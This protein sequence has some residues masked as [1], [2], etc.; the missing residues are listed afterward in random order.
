M[1]GLIRQ[2]STTR[3][4][5]EVGNQ[6]LERLLAGHTRLAPHYLNCANLIF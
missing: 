5:L 2:A 1:D 4:G 6:K 3:E